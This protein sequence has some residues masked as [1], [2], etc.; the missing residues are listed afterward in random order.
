MQTLDRTCFDKSEIP[1]RFCSAVEI[2]NR[3][4]QS[5]SAQS[6]FSLKMR[7]LK[8]NGDQ[9]ELLADLHLWIEENI[10]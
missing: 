9:N 10:N 1:L 6:K 5:L 7:N 2:N 4:L 8:K 3:K